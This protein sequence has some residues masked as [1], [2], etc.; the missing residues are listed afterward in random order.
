[1]HVWAQRL[2]E[3]KNIGYGISP[4]LSMLGLIMILDLVAR[5]TYIYLGSILG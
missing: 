1:M 5:Q 3:P 4:D 2:A